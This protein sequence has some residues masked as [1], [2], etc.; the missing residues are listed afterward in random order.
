MAVT[1]ILLLIAPV[2]LLAIA[3]KSDL[4]QPASLRLLA[5]A[6]GLPA[7]VLLGYCLIWRVPATRILIELHG[8]AFR[9]DGGAP[10]RKEIDQRTP[11]SSRVV[12]GE[13]PSRRQRGPRSV[14]GTLVFQ[15]GRLSIEL[16]PAE[17]R[18]GIIGT[19]SQGF[20]GA[21]EIEDGDQ[22]CIG[23]TCWTFGDGAF[24]AGNQ[25]FPL[26]RRQARI[27]G[28]DWPIPLPFAKPLP[29]T[30]RTYSLDA[31]SQR[32]ADAERLRSFVA[33]TRHSGRPRLVLLDSNIALQRDGRPVATPSTFAI[34]AGERLSFYTLPTPSPE[35][36]A[37]PVVERRSVSY[38]PGQH[39]FALDLDT[40]E[41]HALTPGELDALRLERDEQKVVALAMGD[42]QMVDRS[43]YFRGVS[44]SVALQASSLFEL[45]RFFP[46]DFQSAIR[47]VS[48][49]GPTDTAVGSNAWIGATDLA[50]V[51]MLVLRPPFL[52][53]LLALVLQALKVWAAAASRFTIAQALAAG[54]LEIL[55]SVRLLLGHRVWSMPPHKLEAAELALVAWMMLPWVFLMANVKLEDKTGWRRPE[56]L[57]ALAGLFF[58]AVFCFAVVEGPRRYVW[59]LCH[60]AALAIPFLRKVRLPDVPTR[61]VMAAAIFCLARVVLL[62]FGFK[63]SA[64]LPGGRISLSA[65]YV[66]AAC[67]LEGLFLAH[68][69]RNRGAY[70]RDALLIIVLLWGIPAVLTSDIGLALLNVPVFVLLLLALDPK[71]RP[72]RVVVLAIVLFVAGA[73]LLRL[74][75]PFIS[76]EQTLLELASE[77][78]YARFLHFAAPERL[79]ELA[80]KRGESLAIT[81]A[82]LQQYVSSGVF[83]HGYG[84]SEVSVHLGDTALR[85]FAPAVFVAGEWGLAGTIAMIVAYLLFAFI[86]RRLIQPERRGAISPAVYIA[87]VAAGTI[88]VASIYMIVANHEL[89]L[90]TGKNA[91]LLGLDSAGDLLESFALVLLLAYGWNRG[92]IS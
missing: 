72:L 70:L 22:L 36:V 87:A 56:T 52:L 58:S 18:S 84:R 41:I 12:I 91:Y 59:L 7:V 60:L 67:I 57:P 46:R 26:P 64:M 21:P 4:R 66:P 47:I 23:A 29:A 82:I 5:V 71:S 63:E 51:R 27:P 48:P 44:E 33:F 25:T 24:T 32:G 20:L 74:A 65:I 79:Q 80:T 16:P 43:L 3:L 38:R 37:S 30:M 83:G 28:L 81:S 13:S 17:R 89:V 6:Y 49:R 62:L 61:F 73:P 15:Q 40:P 1:S 88:S 78:N 39:S 77:P 11:G 8:I 53:L 35:F 86:A 90:L 31:L 9:A 75:L 85:D 55:V 69:V 50:S 92:E 42:A 10:L 14:F 54:A 68:V 19:Q 34:K 76:N 2:V 45:S